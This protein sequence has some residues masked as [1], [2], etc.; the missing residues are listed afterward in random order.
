MRKLISRL[1]SAPLLAF[2]REAKYHFI[3]IPKNGGN[4]V[5]RAFRRNGTVSV[6]K[7]YHYRYVDVADKVG[8]HLKFFCIVRNPWSRTA[9]RFVFAKQVSQKWPADDPRRLYLSEASFEDYVR[10]HR[11]FEIP[12]HPGQP[13]MGPMNSWFD[14]LEWISN[15]DGEVVCDCLRLEHLQSDIAS[16]F[17]N[18]IKIVSI[19]EHDRRILAAAFQNNLLEIAVGRVPEKSPPRFC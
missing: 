18:K 14:Q 8:R 7:P 6:T 2:R 10:D 9:S 15:E 3:H 19:R 17:G 12:E 5:R 13:W 11:I 4:S 16:Y 1:L